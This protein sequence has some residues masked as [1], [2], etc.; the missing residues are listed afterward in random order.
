MNHISEGDCIY[1]DLITCIAINAME[2]NNNDKGVC[3]NSPA[4]PCT[5]ERVT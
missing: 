5:I 2:S 4:C 3:D 1:Q